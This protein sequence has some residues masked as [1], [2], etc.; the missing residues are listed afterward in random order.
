M[1]I[2]VFKV[3]EIGKG[4]AERRMGILIGFL[5][6][7]EFAHGQLE[8]CTPVEEPGQDILVRR[9]P[10]PFKQ[11]GKLLGLAMHLPAHLVEC[12]GE[13]PHERHGLRIIPL[14]DA[15]HLPRKMTQVGL[16]SLE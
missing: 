10:V 4:E 7:A 11:P 1:V 3:V 5:C 13:I 16:C 2:H 14:R 15:L 12:L 6:A 9:H 8:E